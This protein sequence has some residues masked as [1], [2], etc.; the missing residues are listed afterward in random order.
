[1]LK[2]SLEI[3]LLEFSD[4]YPALAGVSDSIENYGKKILI[5]EINWTKYPYLP[6]V[7]LFCGYTADEILLKYKVNETHIRAVNTGINTAVHKD[8]C[9]EFFISTGDTFFYNFEFNC[10]G[11]PYT[12]YGK[13]GERELLDEEEVSRIRTYSSLG[14]EAISGREIKEPWELTLAIPFSIFHDKEFQNPGKHPFY[15]NFYKCGDELPTP[16]FL[17]WNPITVE[18]PDFHQPEF[19]GKIRFI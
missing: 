13:R 17:S 11:T 15:A 4:R 18:N 2:K 10:I 8:S 1:M 9:V 6:E 19:F 3:P 16:H 7:I 5:N 14:N 12:A